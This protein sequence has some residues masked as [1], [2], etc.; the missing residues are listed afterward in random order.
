MPQYDVYP[1][2]LGRGYLLDVQTG[3]LSGL[4][5]RIVVPLLPEAVAPRP[6]NRLN[7][8]FRIDG[9]AHVMVTQFLSAVPQAILKSATGTL[10]QEA[11]TITSALDML[12]HGF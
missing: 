6:A 12:T 11:M 10:A 2:P 3:L 7:P 1:D 8:V 4:S 5:T 9:D